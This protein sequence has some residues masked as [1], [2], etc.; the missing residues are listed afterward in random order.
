MPNFALGSKC[1]KHNVMKEAIEQIIAV[2]EKPLTDSERK[3]GWS[4][5][6]KTGYVPVFSRLLAQI[7]KGENPPFL[8]DLLAV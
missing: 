6:I 4:K 1:D 8:R 7:E 5:E 2:L 3:A